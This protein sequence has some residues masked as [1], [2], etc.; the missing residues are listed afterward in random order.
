MHGVRI[1][2]EGFG[3]NSKP[4]VT[5]GDPGLWLRFWFYVVGIQRQASLL[6]LGQGS[7]QDRTGL[8]T[9]HWKMA[10]GAPAFRRRACPAAACVSIT[11]WFPSLK[12]LA[13]KISFSITQKVS[14]HP[15]GGIVAQLKLWL[16]FDV[17]L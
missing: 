5:P 13:T 4:W 7:I 1:L 6:G 16:F 15:H 2:V 14:S 9:H 8:K 3:L 10:I 12:I 17:Q 11:F